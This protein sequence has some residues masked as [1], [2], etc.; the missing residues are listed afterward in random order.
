MYIAS[1][2]VFRA[3]SWKKWQ[4]G[5]A[6]KLN[7]TQNDNKSMALDYKIIRMAVAA[8]FE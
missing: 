4:F 8:E 6:H 3:N 2:S 7:A 5:N 1:S